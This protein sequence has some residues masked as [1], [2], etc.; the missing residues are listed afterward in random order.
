MRSNGRVDGAV[1]VRDALA[2]EPGLTAAQLMRPATTLEAQVPAY[3]ALRT[4]R[5]TRNLLAAV[6]D[7][8]SV[9]GLTGQG[10]SCSVTNGNGRAG[11]TPSGFSELSRASC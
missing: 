1:H 8:G 3:E 9:I 11:S 5:E 6:A 4:M 2:A 10:V 7:D